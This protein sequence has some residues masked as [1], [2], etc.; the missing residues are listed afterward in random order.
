M[1]FFFSSRREVFFPKVEISTH[2][3]PG[4]ARRAGARGT[5]DL[6]RSLVSPVSLGSSW[7]VGSPAARLGGLSR[8]CATRS[9]H[10]GL[11]AVRRAGLPPRV[12][13]H[14]NTCIGTPPMP[15]AAVLCVGSLRAA[16]SPSVLSAF[17]SL[18][19]PWHP[20]PFAPL[21]SVPPAPFRSPR[22]PWRRRRR[23][24]G[25]G[26]VLLPLLSS[27]A[28][29]P[30][31][32]PSAL[33]SVPPCFAPRARSSPLPARPLPARVAR[34]PLPARHP[35]P[36]TAAPFAVAQSPMAMPSRQCPVRRSLAP[37]SPSLVRRCS[38]AVACSPLC[39]SSC[40]RVLQL[41]LSGQRTC[42][43]RGGSA[44]DY[45][46]RRGPRA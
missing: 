35:S 17:R 11:A 14:S 5:V 22:S 30:R 3:T 15:A 8:R 45:R 39:F 44:Q 32:A 37:G 23:R 6:F 43:R 29:S 13:K 41:L 9:P 34:L 36:V 33:V 10:G 28:P 18:S 12:Y 20:V 21:R 4:Q 27:P 2:L 7:R 1:L 16:A 40:P 25:V 42:E 38:V 26:W 31:L 24:Q 19:V 46:T